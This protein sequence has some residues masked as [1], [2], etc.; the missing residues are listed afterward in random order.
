MGGSPRLKF[1]VDTHI[2]IW[3]LLDPK[4]LARRVRKALEN[5]ENELWLSPV[6]VWELM[7][8]VEK[9]RVVLESNVQ[10]WLDEAFRMAPMKEAPITY[11]VARK[12]RSVRL[13]HQDPAD[14]FLAA[15]AMVLEL[16]LITADERMFDSPDFRV[17]QNK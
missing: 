13:P 16:T 14:R 10:N 3:S 6:S 12:S 11:E 7:I 9:G 2:W 4:Q 15:T 8:L 17:L 5:P 1:L